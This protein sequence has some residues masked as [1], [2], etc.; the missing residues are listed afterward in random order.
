MA[1]LALLPALVLAASPS[2]PQE[3]PEGHERA[4]ELAFGVSAG[5]GF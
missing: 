4:N 1:R 5:F 3:R 2:W